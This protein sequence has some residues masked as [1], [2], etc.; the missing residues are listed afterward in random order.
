M[1]TP[2]DPYTEEGV[3]SLYIL[4]CTKGPVERGE[5]CCNSPQ[6]SKVKEVFTGQQG[7]NA[8]FLLL[9]VEIQSYYLVK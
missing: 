7:I 4:L 9:T 1:I 2:L 6:R 8:G 5:E 3:E